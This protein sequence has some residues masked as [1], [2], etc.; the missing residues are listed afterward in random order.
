[1][2]PLEA[3]PLWPSRVLLWQAL[4]GPGLLTT[5]TVVLHETAG[6]DCGHLRQF[7]NWGALRTLNSVYVQIPA[8]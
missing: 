3:S 2:R 4:A 6:A 1:M 8:R 5:Q 7:D